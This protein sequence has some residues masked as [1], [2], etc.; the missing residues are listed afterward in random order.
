MKYKIFITFLSFVILYPLKFISAQNSHIIRFDG[1]YQAKHDDYSS[2]LRFYE[3]NIAQG[4]ISVDSP[5]IAA[6]SLNLKNEI[7]SKGEFSIQDSTILFSLESED[8]V[9]DYK[10]SIKR[11]KLL[12]NAHSHINN[13]R[14]F[15][16]YVF[17]PINFKEI[18]PIEEINE[19]T[20]NNVIK[21]VSPIYKG[22][23]DVNNIKINTIDGK[24]DELFLTVN[25]SISDFNRNLKYQLIT[26]LI[27]D[28]KLFLLNKQYIQKESDII[29]L[30]KKISENIHSIL[31]NAN[32][33]KIK[34]SIEI[35]SETNEDLT[36]ELCRY[37]SERLNYK[38]IIKNN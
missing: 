10:G 24:P 19:M 7:S 2:Y 33:V 16:E 35:V 21:V 1:I 29:E 23:F 14:G 18:I 8:G 11:E 4:Y 9:V 6:R 27:Y 32:I 37:I 28:S 5:E 22:S 36:L 30:N 38:R 31:L 12:L 13:Y 15:K 34:V 20:H 26:F 25:Y 17:I 3:N